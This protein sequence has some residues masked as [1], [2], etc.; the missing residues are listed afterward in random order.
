MENISSMKGKEKPADVFPP[1]RLTMVLSSSSFPDICSHFFMS[2][3][4]VFYYFP[5]LSGRFTDKKL[6]MDTADCILEVSS[7]NVCPYHVMVGFSRFKR[8]Y[9][10][11]ALSCTPSVRF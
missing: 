1:K 9:N 11:Y 6:L 7:L 10:W 8:I 3:F 5:L 2:L 4:V